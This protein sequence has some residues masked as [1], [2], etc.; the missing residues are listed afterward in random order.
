MNRAQWDALADDFE[1]SVTDVTRDEPGKKMDRLVSAVSLSPKNSV[2]VDLGCGVGSFILK[3]G[4]RFRAIVGIEFAPRIIG[5]AKRRCAK[6]PDVEWLA[7][8]I[9]RAADT[10]GRRADLTVCLNVITAP[11]HA[12]RGKLWS[13]IAA[14][15][16]ARRFALVVV[17]SLESSAMI[18][19]LVSPAKRRAE[20]TPTQD[21]LLPRDDAMQ[22]HFSR[23]ELAATMA[24]HDFAVRR[25]ARVFSPWAKEGMRK[26]RAAGTK[27]PW[28]W[29]CLAQRV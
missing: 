26:P 23:R 27:Q 21:G 14:V 24:E 20:Y 22:K 19:G 10:V 6:M 29:A 12:A 25:M 28:D 3:F 2:L 1:T 7:M 9:A 17:P 8:D 13:A 11:G 18:G 15:T 5:R 16:K 4:H